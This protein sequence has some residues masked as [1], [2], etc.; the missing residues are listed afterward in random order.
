MKDFFLHRY[1]APEVLRTA[2]SIDHFQPS[3]LSTSSA[4]SSSSSTSA[5]LTYEPST[6]KCIDV[7][8]NGYDESCDLWSLGVILY[9]M[10]SGE[11]PFNSITAHRTTE[12]IIED[13]THS[14]LSYN[15]PAWKNV[16]QAAKDLIK[17]LF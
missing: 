6:S 14:Q 13:I 11:V 16:S 8:T 12:D 7:P 2:A 9:T 17:G 4:N 3:S 15:A 1:T 10:L 5:S